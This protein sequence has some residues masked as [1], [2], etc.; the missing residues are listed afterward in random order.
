[1]CSNVCC[2]ANTETSVLALTNCYI[3]NVSIKFKYKFKHVIIVKEK[4]YKNPTN[5]QWCQV[6]VPLLANILYTNIKEIIIA[7]LLPILMRC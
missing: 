7:K 6:F 1:M 2:R 5:K 3:S 4:M